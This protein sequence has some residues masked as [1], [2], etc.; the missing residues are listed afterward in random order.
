M[1]KTLKR[2]SR[3]GLYRDMFQILLHLLFIFFL[4]GQKQWSRGCKVLT[5]FFLPWD[6]IVSC[7]ERVT[8]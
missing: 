8:C 3:T 7:D 1:L 2:D 4:E 5:V 6:Y